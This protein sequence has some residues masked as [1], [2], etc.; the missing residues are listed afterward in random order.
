MPRRLVHLVVQPLQLMHRHAHLLHEL[1]SRHLVLLCCLRLQF[2]LL[3]KLLARSELV[4]LDIQLLQCLEQLDLLPA[5]PTYFHLHDRLW[6][7]PE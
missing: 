3:P 1:R 5:P 2:P 7:K 4:L 6:C